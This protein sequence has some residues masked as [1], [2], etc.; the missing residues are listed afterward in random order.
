[1]LAVAA[2]VVPCRRLCHA[3]HRWLLH[4]LFR[5]STRRLVCRACRI[6]LLLVLLLG[7]IAPPPHDAPAAPHTLLCQL[8]LRADSLRRRLRVTAHLML[9]LLL[10][11]HRR[12]DLRPRLLPLP[13]GRVQLPHFVQRRA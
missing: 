1:M 9:C 7:S 10:L 4:L 3:R 6:L 13:Q 12:V 11:L 8:A 5:S 2:A